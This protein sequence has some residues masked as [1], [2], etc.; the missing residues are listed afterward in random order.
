MIYITAKDGFA[1][2]ELHRQT[3]TTLSGV[4]P[5]PS[6]KDSIALSFNIFPQ[7]NCVEVSS[8][9]AFSPLFFCVTLSLIY[10]GE[11]IQYL[12]LFF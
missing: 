7:L 12:S 10:E 11:I 2:T 6:P 4:D 8:S 3:N 1:C 5:L 9:I